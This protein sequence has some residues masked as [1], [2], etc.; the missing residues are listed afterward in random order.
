M[1]GS[2]GIGSRSLL[3]HSA[4][5]KFSVVDLNSF[6]AGIFSYLTSTVSAASTSD[7]ASIYNLPLGSNSNYTFAL[8]IPDDSTDLYFHLSGPASYSWLAVG[9]GSEMKDSLMIVLYSSAN[10][11]S[12][13]PLAINYSREWCELN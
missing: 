5:L 2:L 7:A 1:L 6:L 12:L 10:G 3:S 9:T 13:S 11:K 8:N 4:Y